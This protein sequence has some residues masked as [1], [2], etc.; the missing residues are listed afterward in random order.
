MNRIEKAREFRNMVEANIKATQSLI[1][2]D[3]LTPEELE[4]IINLYP[5]YESLIGKLVPKDT[6]LRYQ[7]ILY[8]TLAEITVS[9]EF[10]PIDTNYQYVKASA[11][12][13]IPI[14]VLPTGYE[15]A[16]DIGDKVIYEPNGKVYISKIE[17]NSQEPTK[18]EP[19]NRY[20]VEF[21]G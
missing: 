7:G 4:D 15:N 19:H 2:V 13:V 6:L 8:K 11:S 20:W 21:I 17:G 16:Y 9:A 14:W 18:D 5:T 12:E 10:N 3:D 1:R